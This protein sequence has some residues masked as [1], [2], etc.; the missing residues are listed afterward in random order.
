MLSRTAAAIAEAVGE[1]E[2]ADTDGTVGL[3]AAAVEAAGVAVG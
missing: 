2:V 1:M 3:G